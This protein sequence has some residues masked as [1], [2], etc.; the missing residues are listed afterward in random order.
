LEAFLII[1]GWMSMLPLADRSLMRS[2][3]RSASTGGVAAVS[4][5]APFNSQLREDGRRRRTTR[6]TS[7]DR[8]FSSTAIANASMAF[9]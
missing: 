3:L 6:L 1:T 4:G 2:I 9:G 8:P 7:R 5:I